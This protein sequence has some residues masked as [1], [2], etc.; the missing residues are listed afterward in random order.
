MGTPQSDLVFLPISF[1]SYIK[2]KKNSILK[3]YA[4]DLYISIAMGQCKS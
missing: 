1:S 3:V 2:K 4:E